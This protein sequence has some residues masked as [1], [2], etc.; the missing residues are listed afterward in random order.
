MRLRKLRWTAFRL[1]LPAGFS[2][3]RCTLTCR[4]GAV[5]RLITDA[6]IVGLGEASPLPHLGGGT[7]QDVLA[8]LDDVGAA[9]VGREMEEVGAGLDGVAAARPGLAAVRCALDVA[10]HDALAKAQGVNVAALLVDDAAWSVAVNATIGAATTPDAHD[11][12][13]AVRDAGFRSVKLKVGMA[14]SVEEERERVAAVRDALGPKISLRLDANGA[15]DVEDAVRTIR[16]LEEYDLEF[17]EQPVRLGD[18]DGMR[19]VRAAVDTP[20]AA[21][22]EITGPDAARR[23]LDA[24][25]AQVLVVKPMLVGGLGLALRV[26]RLAG[27]AGASVVVTTTIDA[28][29]GTAAALHPAAALPP[30]GPA[31]GL[32]TGSL[33]A[34]DLITRPLEACE[35]RMALP[36]GT[37][38]GV[39][40]DERE[41]AQYDGGVDREVA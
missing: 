8:I 31:C 33:L 30:G 4:E 6:G 2:T 22:E 41:L 28:G 32:A 26:A 12:A 34:G 14:R 40:L 39:E 25:A 5:L 16:A 23:V 24:E 37:G 35:G 27:A 17:I 38:L 18:L 13:A 9:L 36:Q 15:W 20:I 7:L 3:S 21:D 11:A 29:V 10:V 19:H 1:P